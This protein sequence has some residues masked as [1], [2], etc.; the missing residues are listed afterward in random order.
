MPDTDSHPLLATHQ[1]PP[2][3]LDLHGLWAVALPGSIYPLLVLCAAVP[4]LHPA[5]HFMVGKEGGIE[6]LGVQFLIVGVACGLVILAR[7]RAALPKVWLAAWFA[8]LVLGMFVLAGEEISWGQH[9]GLWT[10]DDLPDAIKNVNDQNE[11]N[12]HNITNALDQL[13]TYAVM[14]AAF[15]GCVLNPL[16]LRIRGQ[17]LTPDNPGYW[18]W[19]TPACLVAALGV[20]LITWPKRIYERGFGDIPDDVRALWRHSEI[21]EAYIAMLMMLY[22]LSV[23]TRLRTLDR[24]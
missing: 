12:F 19:P 5:Y 9:L 17:R 1:H 14:A 23:F 13:P 11:T 24:R 2:G 18:F 8:F 3:V 20:L 7:Y 16:Y 4:A 22:I 21:H 15:V 6:L 10:A